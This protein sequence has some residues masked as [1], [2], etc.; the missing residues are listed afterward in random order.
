MIHTDADFL[1]LAIEEAIQGVKAR[2]G[3]PFGALVVQRGII[4][5]RSSN[6][7]LLLHD[8]TAHAEIMAIRM[9]CEKLG[10]YQ[11]EDCVLYASCEPCPMCLGAIYWARPIRWVYAATRED[12]AR[13]GFDDR[14]IYDEFQQPMDARQIPAIQLSIAGALDPFDYWQTWG[15]RS[16]Y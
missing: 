4:L 6:R 7:V 12:A 16:L 14:Y 5:S 13:A 2:M 1:A 9:A 10:H 8:P 3:G 11:L 15:D